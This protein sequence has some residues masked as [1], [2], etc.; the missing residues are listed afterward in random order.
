M[1]QIIQHPQ[2][3]PATNEYDIAILELDADIS[4]PSARPISLPTDNYFVAD[5]VKTTVTGWG[6]TTAKGEPSL[7]LLVME[8]PIVSRERCREIL[9]DYSVNERMICVGISKEGKDVCDIDS[10]GTLCD[11]FF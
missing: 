8:L 10:G 11:G 9:N 7:Q 2:H 4:I 1:A 3:D 5:G 6:V